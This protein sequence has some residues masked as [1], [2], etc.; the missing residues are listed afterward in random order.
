MKKLVQGQFLSVS[1]STAGYQMGSAKLRTSQ[2]FQKFNIMST[3]RVVLDK[4]KK[5]KDD[6][7]S[8]AVCVFHQGH[9]QYLPIS[10]LTVSQY[11]QIFV[12]QSMDT[13]SIEF[14]EKTNE[15][16]TNSERIFA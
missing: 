12:L 9:V 11:D 15:L 16:K 7:Y 8:L 1:K 4:R 5:L 3:L 14:R 6:K 13:K 10:S 2:Q